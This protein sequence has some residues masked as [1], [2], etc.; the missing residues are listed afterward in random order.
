MTRRHT[1]LERYFRVIEGVSLFPSGAT[2]A[3]LTGVL[4]MPKTTCHRLLHKLASVGV[5][6]A[7]EGH[8]GTYG[9]G[10]RLLDL[11]Q[12]S[13]PDEW[14]AARARALLREL[15]AEFGETCF[16]AR[17]RGGDIVSIAMAT[18]ESDVRGYVVPGSKLWPH[19]AASAKAILAYLPTETVKAIL[20]SPLPRLALHTKTRVSDLQRELAEVRRSGF[21]HCR[22]ED[23]DGFAGIACPVD[24]PGRPA[25]LSLCVTGTIDSLGRHDQARLAQRLRLVAERLATVLR[26]GAV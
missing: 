13:R 7:G 11:L 22:G 14:I 6:K 5:I 17:R 15:S 23:V 18:P 25:S 4:A 21:A 16:L 2:L 3:Q 20:P 1:P 24:I 19:A 8:G 12:A 9:V 10:P 26:V